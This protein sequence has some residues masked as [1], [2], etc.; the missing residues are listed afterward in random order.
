MKSFKLAALVLLFVLA[1]ANMALASVVN[2]PVT[3]N[4][5]AVNGFDRW[6]GG[7]WSYSSPDANPNS[8]SYYYSFSSGFGSS[9]GWADSYLQFNLNG[10][11]ASNISSASLFMNVLS[12]GQGQASTSANLYHRT[13]ASGATGNASQGLSGDQLVYGFTDLSTIGWNEIDVT[14]YLNNDLAANYNWSV[15]SVMHNGEGYGD[16]SSGMSFSSAEGGYPAYLQ[17][18]YANDEGGSG[19]NAVP[20]PATMALLGSGL[21][22]LVFKRRKA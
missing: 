21:V 18:A 13:D 15:F 14:S 20:E 22:G 11:S 17:I 3:A 6:P 19:N 5:D 4:G 1:T 2:V 7:S 8:A 12:S 16:R 9:A 10:V